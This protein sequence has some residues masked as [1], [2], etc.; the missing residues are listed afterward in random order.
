M[1]HTG[2]HGFTLVELVI[3]LTVLA[4]LAAIAVNSYRDYV[5]RSARTEAMAALAELAQRQEEYFSNRRTY[6]DSLSVLNFS[7]TTPNDLYQLTIPSNTTTSYE[8]RATAINAQLEDETCRIF[9]LDDFGERYAEDASPGNDTTT[10][11][12]ER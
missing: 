5:L 7:A 2:N 11:C 10:E 4:V 9:E 6:T 8:L 3:A 1:R 12:W